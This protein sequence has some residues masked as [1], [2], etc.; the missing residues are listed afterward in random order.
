MIQTTIT[1]G[2]MYLSK[3]LSPKHRTA[4]GI[5]KHTDKPIDS[6]GSIDERIR[7]N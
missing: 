7:I 6:C 2:M 1:H 4:T 3:P 5:R